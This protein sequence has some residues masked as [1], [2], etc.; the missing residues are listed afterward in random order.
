MRQQAYAVKLDLIKNNRKFQEIGLNFLISLIAL[1]LSIITG[2][3]IMALFGNNPFLAYGALVEGA[4]GTPMALTQS[5]TKSVPLLLTGLA[6]A[7]AY[8]CTVFNIGAEGQLLVG[9]MA[10]GIAGTMLNLPAV[11]NIPV[12][13]LISM[14][15]G[16]V[17]A[18]F[19]AALKQ[20]AG[21]NVVISTIM[22]NYVGQYLVQYLI[23]GPFKAEGAASAT[24]AIA[25]TA[26][27]P[28]LLPAPYVLNLGVVIALI[29]AVLVYLLLNRTSLGYEMCA[30]GLNKN[31][32][33][34]NGIN[35]EKNMF[36]ALL[37]S[38]ALAGLAGGIEVTGT[39]GKVING[40]SS[41]YG[42]S[43]IPVALMARNNPFAIIVTALLMGSMRSGS[44]MM[45]SSVGVSKNMVDIIQGLVIV[46]LCS[47]NVIR[48]YLNFPS[49]NL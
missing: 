24:Q 32:S 4:F 16:M 45:Q 29:A 7:L 12:V 19:P 14:A 44:L 20:K 18:F 30:V 22:F 41:N 38:G 48:Y 3:I 31:A 28:K 2:G 47:E 13:L 42:F 5:I 9:A 15:A 23:L 49:L 37:M 21:V 35:V 27:L 36:L 6:V 25:D 10:A 17:W 8:K 26:K 40:F 46:F 11:I 1:V 39:M 33:L 43:G 34:T